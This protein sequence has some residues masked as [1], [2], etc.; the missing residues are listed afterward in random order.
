M[1]FIE[2]K[3]P[4][5]LNIKLTSCGRELLSTG[6]LGFKYFAVGDSEMDYG[7]NTA[8]TLANSGSSSTCYSPYYSRIL[9]PADVN[10]N[11]IS[12]IG[13]DST[14]STFNSIPSIPQSTYIV[15]NTIEP[16]G[17]FTS[18]GTSFL[19]DSNHVKQ[20]DI[21]IQMSQILGGNS[22]NLYKAPT[23]GAS[24]AEPS[25]GDYLLVKWTLNSDTT[26]YT[27]NKNKPTPY[28]IY[29]IS[30]ITP[31][32]S[33]AANNLVVKVDRQLPNFSGIST[34]A[35]A[36]AMDFYNITNLTGDTILNQFSTEYVDQSV[37]AFLTN[38]QCDTAIFPFWNM[39]II[40]TDNIAGVI[41][42]D[43]PFTKYNSVHFGGFVSY[44][45]NQAPILKKLG[46]IHYSNA[47]P[48][49]VYAE[50][51]YQNTPVLDI[52]TI[53]WH[54]T[55]GKTMG[56]KLTAQGSPKLLTG[57]TK[58][59]NLEY[60][61]LCDPIGYPVG[62]VFTDLKIFVIEDQ[63]LLFAM[64][65]KSNRSWTFPEYIAT[66]GG[67]GCVGEGFSLLTFEGSPGS[68][69][70]TGGYA[71]SSPELV[72]EYGMFYKKT[73]DSIWSQIVVG[74]T[75]P[76]G[77]NFFHYDINGL[78]PST[79]YNYKAYATWN[80]TDTVSSSNAF[81]ITTPGTTTT[82]TTAAPT[83][84]TTTSTTTAAPTT[85]TTTTAAPTTS[86]TTTAAPTTSTTTSTTTT[87]TTTLPPL[88]SKI[89]FGSLLGEEATMARSGDTGQIFSVTFYYKI[90]AACDNAWSGNDPNQ[91]TTELL[92][93][94]NGGGTWTSINTAYASIP[95]GAPQSDSVTITGYTTINGI[96]NL[97]QVKVTGTYNCA[98]SQDGQSGTIEVQITG[99]S[100]DTGFASIVCPYR[101]FIGCL[102]TPTIDCSGP[103]PTTTTTTST[104]S[105]TAGPT[106]TTLPP[107]WKCVDFCQYVSNLPDANY[108]QKCVCFVV[109]PPMGA[110]EYFNIC[111]TAH[112]CSDASEGS[113]AYGCIETNG[114]EITIQANNS[115]TDVYGNANYTISCAN[116]CTLGNQCTAMISAQACTGFQLDG[117]N[118]CIYAIPSSSNSCYC[119]GNICTSISVEV[120]AF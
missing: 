76:A 35:K 86:T 38:S 112:A 25:V 48:A 77:I 75:L 5:V 58:S 39:T 56:V 81:V 33:L 44:I 70:G 91:A 9:R 53:M 72:T 26:G 16:V 46:V 57:A 36:G 115:N 96:T 43:R 27:V 73:T 106:T 68:I 83:T 11:I 113:G 93:S 89:Y 116:V 18:G 22:L 82:T 55:T 97:S 4:V 14:G 71:I 41:A 60:Y 95:G 30:G 20:P 61:D 102:I 79:Q 8:V 105:T 87:T 6:S 24:G 69:T 50:G 59:L 31:G 66:L 47:S 84:S 2:K 114:S 49:N 34:T 99:V 21:M 120:P 119:V 65:Y 7:F 42:G 12:F 1:A 23:Y 37:I 118:L 108:Y 51:F 85:S 15:T 19:Y 101:F 80:T 111:L 10:P 54:K 100:V 94:T 3:D 98:Y 110:G 64:S 74:T 78:D 104:T 109:D 117:A 13:K 62:K 103:A 63:E 67:G 92:I 17:F 52:P 45:Q 90:D 28:L 40:Y 32:T 107:V 29:Q 88:N